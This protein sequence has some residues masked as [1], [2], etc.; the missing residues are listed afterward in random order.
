MRKLLIVLLIVVIALVALVAALPWLAAPGLRLALRAGGVEQVAFEEVRLGLDRLEVTRLAL[1]DPPGQEIGYLEARYRPGEL[2]QGRVRSV[3]LQ[4]VVVRGR[5]TEEGVQLAGLEENGDGAGLPGLPLPE[6]LLVRNA[7]LEL[8]TPVGQ[9]IVPVRAE[10]RPRGDLADFTLEI[11][12]VHLA[13]ASA[14]VGADLQLEG[15]VPLPRPSLA[16]LVAEGHLQLS[17]EGLD[18]PGV[19]RGIDGSGRWDLRVADGVLQA[20]TSDLDV[21]IAAPS[22][23]LGE[24]AAALPAP[25]RVQVGAPGQPLTLL[26]QRQDAGALIEVEGPAALAAA[27]P[28]LDATLAGA[29]VL[30]DGLALREV[31]PRSA[32]IA[33][34]G[35]RWAGM[36]LPR[37]DLALDA[38]G[39]LSDLEGRLRVDLEGGG[40]LAP[41]LQLSGLS[42]EQTLSFS[43][44]PEQLTLTLQE[45][46]T[47]RLEELALE[48]RVRGSGITAQLAPADTA[49][50][51]AR[52]E[53]GRIAAWTSAL[54]AALDADVLTVLAGGEPVELGGATQQLH[55]AL[56]GSGRQLARG[57]IRIANG[58]ARLPEREIELQDVVTEVAFDRG[59]L[60]TDQRIPV[61]I[62][63][64]SHGA[65]PPLFPPL[66]LEAELRPEAE[67]IGFA[68][69]VTVA[70]G[71]VELVADGVHD[72]SA[73]RGE[74]RIETPLVT[75]APDRLQPGDLAPALG[76]TL[77]RVSGQ[78]A[79]DGDLAWAPGEVSGELALLLENL[80]FDAGPAR[81][82]GVNGL[83][84]FD[85][86]WPPGTRPRQQLAITL[87]DL[88]LPLTN[89]LI[90]FQLDEGQEAAVERL[91]F[92]WAGGTL[93]ADPFT[94]RSGAEALSL[95]LKAEQ[96]DLGELLE[97]VRLP[98]LTGEGAIRG[99]LPVRIQGGEAVI[100]RG[101]LVSVGPG[102]LRYGPNEQPAAVA[103]GGEGMDLLLQALENFH[104]EELRIT[105]D[106]RTDADM[107]IGLHISGA[108]PELYDGHPIEFNLSL[109]GELAN[110][111]RA[112]LTSYQ[113]PDRIRE[114][115][116]GLQR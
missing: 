38:E 99:L 69:Q 64:I 46:G 89:G 63:R 35:L 51:T 70:D 81:I 72:L 17:A 44:S 2:F 4:D 113:L 32:T 47:L 24:L 75:F 107:D 115:M 87:V 11:E 90:T 30:D 10:L 26:A 92:R 29:L 15:V 25:W 68:G 37:V 83:V 116:Q 62:G 108:N 109:E 48:E 71:R 57:A 36:T 12:Q 97:Q 19:G 27:G 103:A 3:T 67:Q 76:A 20:E 77:R 23:D 56:S 94:V 110:I 40:E 65:T 53:N 7:R 105:L 16:D 22:D 49:L 54:G 88:G 52:L 50:L 14:R 82:E 98:G 79:L 114:R 61:D 31:R 21:H 43:R 104:Y 13:E 112:G 85:R 100:T 106:G 58:R 66:G 41:N 28:M 93:R 34:S 86:L 1:G 102:T 95:T 55:L 45:G 96:L 111:L 59:G 42:L 101:E 73:G 91:R 5:V 60:A 33:A 6:Q 80:S 9:L 8:E 39:S 18:V 78:I 74:A 84:R